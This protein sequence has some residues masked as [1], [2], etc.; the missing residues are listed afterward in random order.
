MKNKLIYLFRLYFFKKIWRN[1]NR[2][3]QTIAGNIFPKNVV[4]VGNYTYGK[5]NIHY[6]GDPE[7]ALQIGCLCSIAD[8]VDFILGG[9][10]NYRHFLTF[11]IKVKFLGASREAETK[12]KIIVQD[13]V[14]IGSHVMVL[15]GVTLGKGSVI[16]AGSVVTKDVPPFS[17]VAGNP[18]KFIREC[19]IFCVNE[20]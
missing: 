15:S 3:N 20:Y 18:A 2:L 7:E 16:G 8:H 5:L 11:P 4:K 19:K 14:W 12:G 9:N 6:W 17:I 13:D 10:H 1:E